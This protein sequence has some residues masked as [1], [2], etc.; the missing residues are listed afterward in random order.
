VA[1]AR[2]TSAG[3]AALAGV[4]VVAG[5]LVTV[6][7]AGRGLPGEHRSAAYAASLDDRLLLAMFVVLVMAGAALVVWSAWPNGERSF[8][9]PPRSWWRHYVL[10]LVLLLG[11]VLFGAARAELRHRDESV[12]P[13]ADRAARPAE[14][15]GGHDRSLPASAK[16][17]IELGAAVAAFAIVTAGRS[18]ARRRMERL[19][20]G[21]V[22]AGAGPTGSVGGGDALEA[23]PDGLDDSDI[24]TEPDARRAVRLAYALLDRRLAGT[25]AARP[26]AATPEEWL[27][28][29]VHMADGVPGAP[30]AARR[31]TRLY[32]RA[33]F[34]GDRHPLTE[35]DRTTAVQ[36]LATLSAAAAHLAEPSTSSAGRGS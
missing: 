31:L 12:I 25:A 32:E 35:E 22:L 24:A 30:A 26:A 18:M 36:A 8:V 17:S 16:A 1:E 29:L 21:A 13:S 2:R 5:G 10:S 33:R 9:A 14:A 23:L 27:A 28:L 34:G 19:A 15:D 6:V 11:Y 4:G 7:L 20:A 3:V